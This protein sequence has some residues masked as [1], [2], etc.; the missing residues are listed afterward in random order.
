M[1]HLIQ[2]TYQDEW[3]RTNNTSRVHKAQGQASY[4]P[5]VPTRAALGHAIGA[6]KYLQ[7]HHTGEEW[8]MTKFKKVTAK[9]RAAWEHGRNMC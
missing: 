5:P 4:I 2:G 8:K 1:K 7:P 6:Q 3:V 9:V